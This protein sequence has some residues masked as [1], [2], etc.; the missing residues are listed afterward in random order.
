MKIDS[1]RDIERIKDTYYLLGSLL[2]T[3]TRRLGRGLAS[4]GGRFL[5]AG[6]GS[7]GFGRHADNGSR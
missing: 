1:E 6:G 7:G 2:G 5:V 3:L 4:G